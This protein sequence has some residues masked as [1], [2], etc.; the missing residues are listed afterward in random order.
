MAYGGYSYLDKKYKPGK[1]DFVALFWA[2]GTVPIETIAE[3]LAAE[4]SVGTWTKL[5][6]MNNKVWKL[7]AKVFKI[8]K[9]SKKSGFIWVAYPYD[10]FDAKNMLQFQASVLGNIF[11]LKELTELVALDITLPKRFQ[12]QFNGPEAGLEGLRSYLGTHKS[13]RPHLGTIVKPKVG[14]SPKEF[15]NVAYEAYSGGCDF[16]KD[17]ENLVDQKFCEF[18]DRVMRMMEVMDKVRGETGKNILYSP[19][20][21]D[22]YEAMLQRRDFLISQGA[23]MAMLDVFIIGYSALQ[24][25]IKQLQRDGFFTH[26]HRAGYAAEARGNFGIS[27]NVH[28][29]FYRLIGVDQ[30]HVGTGVGKMEGGPC[31]IKMLHD[32]AVEKSMAE[33]V[34]L[35]SLG[36]EWDRKIKPMMPVASGG[37]NLGIME[38]LLA[39][40]GYDV[41]VQAGGGIHGHPK[42]TRAGATAMRQS[43]DANLAGISLPKYAKTHKELR[44]A[45]KIWKYHKPD[46]VKKLL[47]QQKKN[48][49]MLRKRALSKGINAIER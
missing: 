16:I 43:I 19:N 11:G 28:Q 17:D 41:T 42:G 29:K 22:N 27:F 47:E 26:A 5:K 34:P 38:P 13:R 31:Y 49:V 9:T 24:D 15:A 48:I 3:A 25:I 35:G 6:T 46:T 12:K 32:L 33:S 7:R 20:I 10:H 45:L 21:T 23:R 2:K 18:E 36:A 39:L 37:V 44:E 30:L 40:H 8:A 4:S 14:L 1:D